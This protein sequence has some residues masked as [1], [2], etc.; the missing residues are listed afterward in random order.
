MN[1]QGTV[2]MTYKGNTYHIP[3]CL[4]IVDTHP[5]NAPMCFVKPTADMLIKVSRFCDHNGKIYLPY[6][7]DWTP[8]S[9][10]LLS[11]GDVGQAPHLFVSFFQ[12][13]SDL[14]GLI[15]VMILTF[16]D[17]PPVYSKP[18]QQTTASPYPA[19]AYPPAQ[20]GGGMFPPYPSAGQTAFPPYPPL[21]SGGYPPYPPAT[22]ASAGSS[23]YPAFPA[24]PGYPP[25]GGYNS[26]F[27]S[28]PTI[29]FVILPPG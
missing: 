13:N 9:T 10:T 29:A 7:H 15:Q 6:L 21:N 1:L 27:V 2:P 24:M 18:K 23:P 5:S 28:L 22:G 19:Q 14:L 4:W 20:P 25:A 26:N 17:F 8:V 11:C 3:V 16:G 12:S